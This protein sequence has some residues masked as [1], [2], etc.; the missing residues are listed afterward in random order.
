MLAGKRR[1]RCL[2]QD[3]YERA[4]LVTL[5][6][7]LDSLAADARIRRRT[8]PPGKAGRA[9]G[10]LADSLAPAFQPEF[11]ISALGQSV[12]GAAFSRDSRSTRKL[13]LGSADKSLGT[14]PR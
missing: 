11:G 8:V 3:L 12:L 5:Q 4:T 6:E 7:C 1:S 13:P 10:L 9:A 14:Q 2:C